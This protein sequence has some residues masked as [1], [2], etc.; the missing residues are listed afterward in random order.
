MSLGMIRHARRGPVKKGGTNGGAAAGSCT[1]RRGGA[2]AADPAG[3][4]DVDHPGSAR[5]T[6]RCEG[7]EPNWTAH[8][9]RHTA[10]VAPRLTVSLV[11]G[12]LVLVI[13]YSSVPGVD[14]RWPCWLARPT[15]SAFHTAVEGRNSLG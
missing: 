10:C 14:P 5:P 6:G 13:T 2:G 12:M 1:G 3:S 8:A 9:N 15:P 11:I 7:Y 4:T